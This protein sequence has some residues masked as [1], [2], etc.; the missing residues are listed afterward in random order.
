MVAIDL[1]PGS[2]MNFSFY[3]DLQNRAPMS[4]TRK[5]PVQAKNELEWG[6]VEFRS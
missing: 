6:T 1:L 5:A 2:A 4:V 3:L